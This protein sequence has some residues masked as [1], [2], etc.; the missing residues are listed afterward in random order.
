[1]LMLRQAGIQATRVWEAD[2]DGIAYVVGAVARTAF[3]DAD[4]HGGWVVV[5]TVDGWGI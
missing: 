5:A 1:M 2:E 3:L 4:G